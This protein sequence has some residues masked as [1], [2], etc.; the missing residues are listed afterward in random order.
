MD[1]SMRADLAALRLMLGSVSTKDDAI[2]TLCLG[3]AGDW[4]YD[5]VSSEYVQKREVQEAVLLL[6]SRLYKRRQSPEGVAGWEDMGAVRVTSRDPDIERLIEQYVDAY[7]V[8]GI[9]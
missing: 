8:L 9:G 3:A 4:I 2:L 1:G 6:A 7:K 5:R